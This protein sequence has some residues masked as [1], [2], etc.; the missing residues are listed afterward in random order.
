MNCYITI[1]YCSFSLQARTQ[2]FSLL[3]NPLKPLSIKSYVVY[4]TL[5]LLTNLT[6]LCLFSC[7]CMLFLISYTLVKIS[8]FHILKPFFLLYNRLFSSTSQSVYEN[9][10]WYFMMLHEYII[11]YSVLWVCAHISFEYFLTLLDLL[12]TEYSPCV[13]NTKIL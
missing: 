5:K 6:Q 2:S 9:I 8:S 1:Q 10:S 4:I 13:F 11:S 7:K 12:C 3:S